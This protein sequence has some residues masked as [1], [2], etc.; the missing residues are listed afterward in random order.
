[1]AVLLVFSDSV[2]D[3]T[4]SAAAAAKEEEE[5]GEEDEASS[6]SMCEVTYSFVVM[7]CSIGLS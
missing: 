5:E 6:R 7:M 2:G 1:M 4:S 3:M